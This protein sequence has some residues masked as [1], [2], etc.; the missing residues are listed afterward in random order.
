MKSHARRAPEKRKFTLRLPD[1][2]ATWLENAAKSQR[3][4]IN[5]LVQVMVGL[6]MKKGKAE[7]AARSPIPKEFQGVAELLKTATSRMRMDQCR[8]RAL[9]HLAQQHGK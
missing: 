1:E 4:S 8:S 7:A 2:E 9:G 3:V 5:K 6:E